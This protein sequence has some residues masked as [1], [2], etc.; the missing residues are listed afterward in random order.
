M[1]SL[2]NLVIFAKDPRPG[3]VKTRLSPPLPPETAAALAGAFVSDL[4]RR[5][6]PLGCVTVALPPGDAPHRLAKLLPADV[7]FTGQGPGD[8]GAKLAR[9]LGDALAAGAGVAVAIGADHP[10]VP[11]APLREAVAAARDGDAG[12]IPTDDGGFACIALSRPVPGLF[13]DVAWSTPDAA[14]GVRNN[15]LRLGVSLRETGTWYDV[16]DVRDLRRFAAEPDARRRCPGTMRVLDAWRGALG[17]E[18][19]GA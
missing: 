8:L 16:D 19:D 5:L 1:S 6:L 17:K 3:H 9:V 2:T 11:L 18:G 7:A 10:H 14:A 13:A 15:A 4:A 12:W